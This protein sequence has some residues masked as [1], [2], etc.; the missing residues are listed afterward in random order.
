MSLT[1]PLFRFLSRSL[2]V[3][4]TLSVVLP[5]ILILGTF[6][7]V[8][9]AHHRAATLANLTQLSAR[10]G[11]IVGS[12]F[13]HEMLESDTAEHVGVQGLMDVMG[14]SGVF[15]LVYLLDS[16]GQVVFA[17]NAESVG[18]RLDYRHPDCQLCH[19]LRPEERPDSVIVTS[20]DGQ[21]VFR[22]MYPLE[23]SPACARC[24]DPKQRLIGLLLTDIPMAPL[25]EPLAAG[26]RQDLLRWAGI[27]LAS[28]VI[29][30]L[31]M[32]RVVIR[33]LTG[34]VQTLGRFDR[35]HSNLRLPTGSPDEIGLLVAAFNDMG[36]RIQAEEAENQVLSEDLRRLAEQRRALLKRLITA[37][38]EERPFSTPADSHADRRDQRPDL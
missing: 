35:R 13:R 1:R 15:Q 16:S 33:R 11:R 27:I 19:G 30:N 6:A 37:Q 36:Q 38:E 23:N 24:H 3:K 22:N 31:A 8:E 29:I 17:P 9:Y 32:H 7:V 10:L 18:T 21:R 5:L 12:N 25:E 28:V 14:A 4:I 20:A 26:L 2:R 34:V